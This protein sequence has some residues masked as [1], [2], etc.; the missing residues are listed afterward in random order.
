MRGIGVGLLNLAV[1][2]LFVVL[3]K[4]LNTSNPGLDAYLL[5]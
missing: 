4:S 2:E 3:R 1:F 5:I